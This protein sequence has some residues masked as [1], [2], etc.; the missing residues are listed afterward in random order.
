DPSGTTAGD[1]VGTNCGTQQ[2]GILLGQSGALVNGNAAM[3]FDGLDGTREVVAQSAALTALNGAAALT[4][5]TWVNPLTMTM[6]SHYRL[7][8]SF[9]GQAGDYVGLSDWSGTPRVIASLVINGTQRVFA[10]G[11]AVTAGTWYHVVVTYDGAAA[12]LYVNGVAV[13]QVA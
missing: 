9:A 13:A 4:L 12:V 7:F 5:E 8:Y 3:A 10:A 1:M 2:G 6:P 11:P